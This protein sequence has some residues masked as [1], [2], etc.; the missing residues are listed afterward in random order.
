MI[1]ITIRVKFDDI[2]NYSVIYEYLTIVKYSLE[3]RKKP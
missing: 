3:K 1:T 2:L